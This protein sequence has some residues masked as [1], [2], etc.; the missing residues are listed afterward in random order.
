MKHEASRASYVFQAGPCIH[1]VYPGM[2]Y[3]QAHQ[4]PVLGEMSFLDVIPMACVFNAIKNAIITKKL[5]QCINMY[6]V[7][8]DLR[9]CRELGSGG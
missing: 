5:Q 3:W 9:S 6:K 7:D 1:L 4:K 2:I 8:H